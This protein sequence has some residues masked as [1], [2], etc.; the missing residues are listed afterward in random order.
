MPYSKKAG[1][2]NIVEWVAQLKSENKL[3]HKSVL[4][5]G[6]GEGTYL[7]WLKHKYQSK[8]DWQLNAGPLAECTW[9][10]VEIWT[11]YI[12]EFDLTS[13]YE[14]IINEDIRKIDYTKIGP[15]DVAIAGDV[16]EHMSK[17]DAIK[18]VDK[19]LSVA[20]HLFISIPIIH[21]P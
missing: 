5:I 16:L 10:G 19:V 4:D 3:H 15:F 21:Y 2:P 13:K 7:N 14:T 8:Q 9:T 11:P 6:V 12:K 17:D 20:T 18:V 1:K